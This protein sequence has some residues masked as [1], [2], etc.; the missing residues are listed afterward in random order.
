M[1]AALGASHRPG[2]QPAAAG[3]AAAASGPRGALGAALMSRAASR[4][5]RRLRE[6][7]RGRAGW[8]Q[9]FRSTLSGASLAE[10]EE[11]TPIVLWHGHKFSGNI[12][13][14]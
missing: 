3:V 14:D 13:I 1:R 5:T 9:K 2:L 6:R 11:N 8:D 7:G 12:R 10:S 4:A